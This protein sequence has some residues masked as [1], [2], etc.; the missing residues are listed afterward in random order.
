MFVVA[1][2]PLRVSKRLRYAAR[3]RARARYRLARTSSREYSLNEMT[4]ET[5]VLGGTTVAISRSL[6]LDRRAIK[7]TARAALNAPA[8]ARDF[9]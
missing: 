1:A 4:L 8:I 9:P 5:H 2:P 6:M 7:L 3:A